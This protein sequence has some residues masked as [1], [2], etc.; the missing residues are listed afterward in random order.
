MLPLSLVLVT[1]ESLGSE[2]VP[3]FEELDSI[4]GGF[5]EHY[6]TVDAPSVEAYA[7]LP[8]EHQF[9]EKL[10]NDEYDLIIGV[11]GVEGTLNHWREV[12]REEPVE[13]ESESL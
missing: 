5:F 3:E 2:A 9:C 11:E 7:I 13:E 4:L 12:S 1:A 10:E 6:E 8:I